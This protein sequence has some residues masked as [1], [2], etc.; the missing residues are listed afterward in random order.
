M[1][2]APGSPSSVRPNY[3]TLAVAATLGLLIL[4]ATFAG[5]TV[6]PRGVPI[7]PG[8]VAAGT[9]SCPTTP[10]NQSA[11]SVTTNVTSGPAPLTVGFCS[12][13]E[14][15]V[16][17][18][19]WNFGN[20]VTSNSANTSYTF[21]QIGG[22]DVTVNV[23]FI[24]GG[25]ATAS[26]PVTVTGGSPAFGVGES[27][28]P[29]TGN[30][31]LTV[32]ATTTVSNAVGSVSYSWGATQ[33]NGTFQFLTNTSTVN[34]TVFTLSTLG[35]W[36]IEGMATDTHGDSGSAWAVVDVQNG[37]SG[38]G[39]SGNGTGPG[40]GNGTFQV[41]GSAIPNSAP[42]P[43]TINFDSYVIGNGGPFSY[44][45]TFGD[46][47][48]GTGEN[49]THVYGAPNTYDAVV[50]AKNLTGAFSSASVPVTIT[51]NQ[52]GG[53]GSQLNLAFTVTPNRGSAPLDATLDLSA[54]GGTAPY[55]L[56]VGV[57]SGLCLFSLTNWSGALMSTPCLLLDA[58]N[59]TA[60]ATVTDS[61]AAQAV[62]TVPI[63]VTV[64]SPLN[65]SVEEST[66]YGPAPLAV[67]FLA[68]VTGGTAPYAIQWAWGDG[69]VG[70]SANG[71]IVA[72]AYITS[73]VYSP[74]LTVSD[75]TGKNVTVTLE[76]V[77]VT[78]GSTAAVK[79]TGLLPSGGTPAVVLEYLGIAIAGALVSGLAV[80]Y[81]LRQRGRQ[82]EGAT[83][84]AQLETNANQSAGPTNRTEGER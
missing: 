1:T 4:A 64:G 21:T 14:A 33:T 34:S 17:S 22:Y 20:N 69:T 37:S 18:T 47:G 6:S 25:Y 79:P 51:G 73:G 83:L 57:D 71:G 81:Y 80:G 16:S 42:A 55:S 36:Y 62:D 49:L 66:P 13:T 82:K 19:L 75:A 15:A 10:N 2:R 65:V 43:A 24:A 50:T 31:S 26:V 7:S 41:Y 30:S 76:S 52:S 72:H 77:N 56:S 12:A 38:G 8:L 67:G 68:T 5:P 11:L 84:V 28:S 39:G 3:R 9:F 48:N 74:R 58:G 54:T 44:T 32:T 78:S 63:V 45:W 53:N 40:G 46:G 60:H 29:R 70:S 61:V 23:A 27:V 35:A 59:Y